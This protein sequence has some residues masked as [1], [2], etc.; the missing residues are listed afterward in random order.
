MQFWSAWEALG[1]V[2]KSSLALEWA[3]TQERMNVYQCI[4]WMN[5]QSDKIEK[6][7]QDLARRLGVNITAI[8]SELKQFFRTPVV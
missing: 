3:Y 1:G 2:G 6:N 8:G 4:L 7:L 5:M